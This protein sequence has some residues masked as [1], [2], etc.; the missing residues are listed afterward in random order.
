MRREASRER[1]KKKGLCE[2][3]EEGKGMP[4]GSCVHPMVQRGLKHVEALGS[5]PLILSPVLEDK[6]PGLTTEILPVSETGG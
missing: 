4:L 1:E 3:M 6:D 5:I 2:C